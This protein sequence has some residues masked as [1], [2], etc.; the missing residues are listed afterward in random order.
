MHLI[1]RVVNSSSPNSKY[2][3]PRNWYRL[4]IMSSLSLIAPNWLRLIFTKIRI[5]ARSTKSNQ[6]PLFYTSIWVNS[7]RYKLLVMPTLP[8][9]SRNGSLSFMP[10][11][12][13]RLELRKNSSMLIVLTQCIADMVYGMMDRQIEHCRL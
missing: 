4:W 2:H 8:T 9:T 1:A 6:S 3:C 12:L 11:G 10:I 5:S 13:R 7:F